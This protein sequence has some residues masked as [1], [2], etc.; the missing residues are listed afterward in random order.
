M[1]Q[2]ATHVWLVESKQYFKW[3]QS[4]ELQPSWTKNTHLA[5]HFSPKNLKNLILTLNHHLISH[6]TLNSEKKKKTIMTPDMFNPIKS[7]TLQQQNSLV[8]R[9][10][11]F[12]LLLKFDHLWVMTSLFYS[13]SKNI[14][15]KSIFYEPDKRVKF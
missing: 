7:K 4:H 8:L 15:F 3:Q 12:F 11:F 14:S 2:W 13:V 1:I 6:K 9:L 10:G 5:T